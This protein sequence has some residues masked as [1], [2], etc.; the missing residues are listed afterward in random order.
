MYDNAIKCGNCQ[1]Y[2]METNDIAIGSVTKDD[3]SSVGIMVAPARSAD[4]D[5]VVGVRMS[6]VGADV[7]GAIDSDDVDDDDVR[8]SMV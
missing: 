8:C 4:A 7:V 3:N 5:V 1:K 6:M 2:N